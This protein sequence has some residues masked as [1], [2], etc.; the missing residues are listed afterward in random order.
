MSS[1]S[2]FDPVNYTQ[3][4]IHVPNAT[5]AFNESERLYEILF[6]FSHRT[7]RLS[8]MWNHDSTQRMSLLSAWDCRNQ[9]MES[10]DFG[11]LFA[12][13]WPTPPVCRFVAGVGHAFNQVSRH[14]T[15]PIHIWRLYPYILAVESAPPLTNTIW[16]M[17]WVSDDVQILCG[18]SYIYFQTIP[19]LAK[20]G[21]V[22]CHFTTWTASSLLFLWMVNSSIIVL[23]PASQRRIE[24][25][26]PAYTQSENERVATK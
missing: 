11:K 15:T 20:I 10:N 19:Y 6:D 4:C 16:M 9:G 21:R 24:R 26:W 23:S 25:S 12:L 17:Q 2:I 8:R 14:S 13:Q 3:C 18:Y 1:V 7:V 22:G 5:V